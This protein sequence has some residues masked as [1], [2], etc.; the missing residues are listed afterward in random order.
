MG[1]FAGYE[2]GVDCEYGQGA[3]WGSRGDVG[4][5]LPLLVALPAQAEVEGSAGVGVFVGAMGYERPQF[6]WGLEGFVTRSIWHQGDGDDRLYGGSGPLARVTF[7]SDS[8]TRVMFGVH[9]GQELATTAAVDAEVGLTFCVDGNSE[10]IWSL[11]TGLMAETTVF[12]FQLRQDWLLGEHGFGFG[13]RVF[14]TFRPFQLGTSVAGRPYRDEMGAPQRARLRC[15][16]RFDCRSV[17]ARRWARRAR[18]EFDSI[19]AFL[20]LAAELL[21]LDAPSELVTRALDAAQDELAH[22]RAARLLAQ[23]FGGAPLVLLPSSFQVR[24]ALPRQA[25]L[26]R[27]ARE[28]WLDGCLNEGFASAEAA[29]EAALSRDTLEAR[30][31]EKIAGDEARHAS[32][33]LDVLRWAQHEIGPALPRSWRSRLVAAASSAGARDAQDDALLPPGMR[34]ELMRDTSARARQLLG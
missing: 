2:C 24:P 12:N 25:A 32:L 21:T 8:R 23:R 27:L 11:H 16:Q 34:R 31:S 7:A 22:T 26:R 19:A 30:V 6:Y 10:Q 1:A 15:S 17:A 4:G 14:P 18:E 28:A 13:L 5:L 3:A 20:Q 33:G 29:A 9:G